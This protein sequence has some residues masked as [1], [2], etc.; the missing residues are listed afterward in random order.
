MA[1][2]GVCTTYFVDFDAG[3]DAA[4]G[5]SVTSAWKHAPGD[6]VASG[7]V[8]KELRPGDKILFK[9][10]VVYRGSILAPSS[11]GASA[12]IVYDGNTEGKYGAGPATLD[13]GEAVMGWKKCTSAQDAGG[14]ASWNQIYRVDVPSDVLVF[15]FSVN[16]FEGEVPGILARSPNILDAYAVPD[17][18]DYYVTDRP[19]DVGPTS[20]DVRSRHGALPA[21]FAESAWVSIWIERNLV[22][23][24]KVAAVQGTT[25][26]YDAVKPHRNDGKYALWN[27]PSLIDQPGEY[28]VVPNGD[29][30]ILLYWP[31]KGEPMGVSRSVRRNGFDFGKHSHIEVRNFMVRRYTGD[32]DDRG[33]AGTIAEGAEGARL[34]GL[35][36]E[37]CVVT[38]NQSLKKNAAISFTKCSK[39]RVAGNTVVENIGNPGIG[40]FG[41]DHAIIE[42]NYLRRNG[43][44]GVRC[45]TITDSRISENA[46][47]EHTGTHA[48]GITVYV[49]SKN[50]LVEKNNVRH[51]LFPC[52]VQASS[53][54]QIRQNIFDARKLGSTALALYSSPKGQP[55]PSDI[56][57]ENNSLI[58]PEGEGLRV[59][60]GIPGLKVFNN[61]I[62]G[63]PAPDKI[64][65]QKRGNFY[66]RDAIMQKGEA[67]AGFPDSYR[68]VYAD[69]AKGDF[70]IVPGSAAARAGVGCTVAEIA[71]K[72]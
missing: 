49:G 71:G 66:T 26:S 25:I 59:D 56:T 51:G 21:G 35:V 48:N 64:K 39:I 29:K 50:V 31:R 62:D 16:L 41:S 6:P 46:V 20:T 36:V 23:Y 1:T 53:G 22:A 67:G 28:A 4:L 69:G 17:M 70:R 8:A 24:K 15:P 38:Q 43:G 58:A 44:T 7:R 19:S 14:S 54:I 57:V 12:P 27:H 68:G 10:G 18:E 55:A 2:S 30:A 13:G 63:G 72:D 65:M 34:E 37:N 9:G 5:T 52:T 42:R 33:G 32:M 45:F 40:V 60:V 11:G 47:F 3:D 61:I